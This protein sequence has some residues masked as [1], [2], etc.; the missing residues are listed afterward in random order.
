MYQAE[1]LVS[2]SFPEI[3]ELETYPAKVIQSYL[4][5]YTPSELLLESA[6]EN[7][8]DISADCWEGVNIVLDAYDDPTSLVEKFFEPATIYEAIIMDILEANTST[9][10]IDDEFEDNIKK[11]ADFFGLHFW[12]YER[13][14]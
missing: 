9:D 2:S 7:N 5:L 10:V 11:C 12:F 3:I 13:F 1:M 8:L 14:I 6:Y 4:D